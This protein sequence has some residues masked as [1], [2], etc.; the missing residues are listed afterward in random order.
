MILTYVDD[1]IILSKEES[2]SD[3]IICSLEKGDEN[4]DF[5]NDEDLEQYLGMNLIREDG[6]TLPSHI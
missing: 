1:C 6:K 4:F 5:T 3:E 2:T